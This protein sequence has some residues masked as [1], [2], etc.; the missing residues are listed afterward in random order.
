MECFKSMTEPQVVYLLTTFANMARARSL[1]DSDF[2][3]A[4]VR[5]IYEV[6]FTDYR[7]CKRLSRHFI[8]TSCWVIIQGI[9]DSNI[10]VIQ[11]LSLMIHKAEKKPKRNFTTTSPYVTM[12][13]G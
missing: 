4:V 11:S 2:I 9:F 3:A 6:I 5:E 10:F 1:E 13:F 7:Y 12:L 8:H